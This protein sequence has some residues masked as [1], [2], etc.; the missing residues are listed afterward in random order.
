M[1]SQAQES[2][3]SLVPR[4]CF[5]PILFFGMQTKE[6]KQGRPGDEASLLSPDPFPH[7][8]AG[9]GHGTISIVLTYLNYFYSA[10]FLVSHRKENCF[11][12]ARTKEIGGIN[13]KQW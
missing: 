11:K 5:S 7:G 10:H 3:L 8:R 1:L 4:P 12:N 2:F 6:Q 13:T 9:S